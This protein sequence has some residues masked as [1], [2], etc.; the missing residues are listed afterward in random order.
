M[1][2][3]LL[4]VQEWEA[5]LPRTALAHVMDMLVMPALRRAVTAWEP[6][7]ACGASNPEWGA[8]QNEG[9][10]QRLKGRGAHAGGGVHRHIS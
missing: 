10:G 2:L 6:R 4:S 7:Q 5:L 1:S 3:V 8:G 9:V